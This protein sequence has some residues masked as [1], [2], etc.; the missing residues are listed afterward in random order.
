MNDNEKIF[1]NAARA[2]IIGTCAGV[3]STIVGI[4]ALIVAL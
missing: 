3:I 4:I 2:A 1:V